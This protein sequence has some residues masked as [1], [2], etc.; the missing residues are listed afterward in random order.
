MGLPVFKQPHLNL[1]QRKRHCP[2]TLPLELHVM[3]G[4][5]IR[6][7]GGRLVRNWESSLARG[8]KKLR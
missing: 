8:V 4:W 3:T 7:F 2:E 6:L 1:T 5:D